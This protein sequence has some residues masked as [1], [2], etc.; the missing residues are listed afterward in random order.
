M[1]TGKDTV[2][3]DYTPGSFM[4]TAGYNAGQA[5]VAT[6]SPV[7]TNSVNSAQS[8]ITSAQNALSNLAPIPSA[9]D[10]NAAVN[11]ANDTSSSTG[12]MGLSFSA[13]NA[14][15]VASGGVPLSI[16]QF[17]KM[18]GSSLTSGTYLG[19]GTPVATTTSN[20]SQDASAMIR[21]ELQNWFGGNQTWIAEATQWLTQELTTTSNTSQIYLDMTQQPFYQ[22][23]FAGNYTRQ[24]NGLN[25]LSEADYISLENQYANTFTQYGVS[26]LSTQSEFA[27]LIGNDISAT[28]LNSRVQLA[29]Q[30]VQ[31]ADP[32]VLATLQTYYP[33][34]SQANL[35]SYFLNPAATLPQLT[36]QVANADIGAA[37]TQQ[38]L[39]ASLTGNANTLGSQALGLY[40]V[41]YSQAQQGYGK[42]AQ[43]LPQAERLSAIYGGQTGINY[44]QITGEQQYLENSGA[45]TLQQQKLTQYEEAQFAGKSGINQAD[46]V[47]RKSMQGK[48]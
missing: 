30:N 8:S 2:V 26:N 45:A 15:L 38:G 36:Q 24:A 31:Y 19:F 17:N 13:N 20:T 48:F 47:L 41:T 9:A 46:T 27:N 29:V 7:A 18:T 21:A 14:E 1:A 33:G 40:G 16:D 39:T 28:E 34:V 43:V 44:N 37:A 6:S 10:I 25:M 32:T 3:L 4:D 22:S 5:P 42:V 23:R 35:V 11:A 12:Y